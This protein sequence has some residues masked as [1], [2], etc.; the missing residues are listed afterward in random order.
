[1]HVDPIATRFREVRLLFVSHR[2][3]VEFGCV[4]SVSAKGSQRQKIQRQLTDRSIQLV[5]GLAFVNHLADHLARSAKPSSL[6]DYERKL[7]MGGLIVT[8]SQLGFS[9][10][11]NSK[12]SPCKPTPCLSQPKKEARYEWDPSDLSPFSSTCGTDVMFQSSSV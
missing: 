8:P 2:P 4:I 1:M 3:G 9:S 6:C 12:R 10:L 11:M 5:W 7:T